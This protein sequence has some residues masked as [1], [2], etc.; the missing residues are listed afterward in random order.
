MKPHAPLA[1]VVVAFALVGHTVPHE[2]QF[3]VSVCRFRHM[4][5][6]SV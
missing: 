2:P 1:Q 3:E 5:A 6:Q 4:P